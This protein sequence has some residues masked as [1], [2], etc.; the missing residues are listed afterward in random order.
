MNNDFLFQIVRL[1]FYQ[2]TGI[3]DRFCFTKQPREE[4]SLLKD[5]GRLLSQEKSQGTV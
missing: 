5:Y 2:I 1:S 4:C 3:D